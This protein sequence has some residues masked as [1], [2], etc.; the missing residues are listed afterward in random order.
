VTLDRGGLELQ[1]VYNLLQRLLMSATEWQALGKGA[2]QL[3]IYLRGCLFKRALC[4]GC[5]M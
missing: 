1:E 4:C 2:V 3:D 5:E